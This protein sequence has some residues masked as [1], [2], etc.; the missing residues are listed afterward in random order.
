MRAGRKGV[1]FFFSRA[2]REAAEARETCCSRIILTSVEKPGGRAQSGG[3]PRLL[4][5][6]A[7]SL[8]RLARVFA[9]R[10][11]LLSV[12]TSGLKRSY[13]PALARR[14][15][16]GQTAYSRLRGD[17]DEDAARYEWS[18]EWASA[19]CRKFSKRTRPSRDSF[20]CSQRV[21]RLFQSSK[22]FSR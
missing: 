16:Q 12:S 2:N 14:V 6:D 4:K 7:R 13:L 5:M 20:W 3:G 21:R 22:D 10:Q 11:R 8:S 19:S 15:C 1:V 18:G 9:A 17:P